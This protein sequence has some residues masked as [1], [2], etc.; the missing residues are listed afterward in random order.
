MKLLQII[1]GKDKGRVFF[2]PEDAGTLPLG[3]GGSVETRLNDLQVSRRHC[4]VRVSG[5]R[6]TVADT[7]SSLGTF[8]NKQRVTQQELRVGDVLR[9]GETELRLEERE[10]NQMVTVGAEHLQQFMTAPPPTPPPE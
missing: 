10:L 2:L 7:N 5:D 3:R 6:V 8:V 1:A 9:L 4:E